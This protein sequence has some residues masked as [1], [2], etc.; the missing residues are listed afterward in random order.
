[1]TALERTENAKR[2]TVGQDDGFIFPL[3]VSTVFSC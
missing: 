3:N 2:H 1:M